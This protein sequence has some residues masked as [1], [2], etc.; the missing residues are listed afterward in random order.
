MN[1]RHAF[2]AG[3]FADIHKHA[4]LALL[5]KFL[6]KKDKPFLVLDTHAGLG[7]Y[8]L[9]AA[10][11]ERTQEWR[12]GI[13][14]VLAES[15][16]PDEL[17]PYLDVVNS[18]GDTRYPGS[19]LI[20]ARLTR[21]QDRLVFCELHPLDVETLRRRL[22]GEARASIHHRD[23]YEALKAFLPPPER[24]GL[25]LIDPPFEDRAEFSALK[26]GLGQAL[27][28]WPNGIFALWYPIKSR[29]GVDRFHQDLQMLGLPPTFA[30]ELLIHPHDREDRLNGSGMVVINPPWQLDQAVTTVQAWLAPV[31]QQ[32]AGDQRLVWLAQESPT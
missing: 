15:T 18:L 21:P 14:R 6:A 4:I 22:C 30:A 3:N 25:V 2:H 16:P 9:T 1:Y 5:L 27:K 24:R 13:G 7:A 29:Q 31:L 20:A 19:P 32:S 23:G 17:T 8:D 26:K 28:R 12:S 11:A 10:Q